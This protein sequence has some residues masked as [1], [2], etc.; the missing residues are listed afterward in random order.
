M[1]VIRVKRG[2]TTPTTSNLTHIGELAFDYQNNALFARSASSVIRIGGGG[3]VELVAAYQGGVPSHILSHAFD[4]NYIYRV[5]ALVSSTASQQ[6]NSSINYRATN[7][8]NNIGSMIN[9]RSNDVYSGVT[10][11]HSRNVSTFTIFDAY[12]GTVTATNGVTKVIDF[13]LIP[14][15]HTSTGSTLQWSA[16]GHSICTATGQGNTGITYSEFAH[17]FNGSFGSV[18]IN[19]GFTTGIRSFAV[20]LYRVRRQ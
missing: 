4:R 15:L 3:E 1:A 18:R 8:V 5:V 10:K 14:F 13:D 20:S 9:V 2:T 6:V 12:S 11:A 16:K 17:S 19:S 7:H